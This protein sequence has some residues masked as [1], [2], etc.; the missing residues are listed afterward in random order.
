[1]PAQRCFVRFFPD[2]LPNLVLTQRLN[3]GYIPPHNRRETACVNKPSPEQVGSNIVFLALLYVVETFA[4]FT[5]GGVW[6]TAVTYSPFGF[7]APPGPGC[8]IQLF[9]PLNHNIAG[10][11]RPKSTY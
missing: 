10:G 7:P 4:S 1:V 6:R 5:V 9:Y 2:P 3:V 11:D 8:S